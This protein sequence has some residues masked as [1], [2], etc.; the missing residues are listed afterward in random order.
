MQK[1]VRGEQVPSGLSVIPLMGA[2]GVLS[3]HG[4]AKFEDEKTS[5]NAIANIGPLY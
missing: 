3:D 2:D 1:E 4:T 5:E